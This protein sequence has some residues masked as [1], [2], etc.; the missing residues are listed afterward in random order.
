MGRL[1]C[2]APGGAHSLEG[3]KSSALRGNRIFGRVAGWEVVPENPIHR[4]SAPAAS[5]KLS[6]S[7]C[8][9]HCHSNIAVE[10][11]TLRRGIAARFYL[12]FCPQ[13]SGTLFDWSGS[14][15]RR[16]L[17]IGIGLL[18]IIIIVATLTVS[19]RAQESTPE[20]PATGTIQGTLRDDVG[21]PVEG[22]RVL[23]SSSA[24][25]TKGLTRS[26]KDGAYVSESVPPGVY[27]VRVEGRDML[28]AESSV[29]VVA[30]GEVTADFKWERIT[31]G[32]GR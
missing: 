26:G 22:A 27:V 1:F 16:S 19:L 29:T 21:A 13:E 14:L 24:T 18:F 17:S 23:Y 10:T 8:C 28:P 12:R 3:E 5:S 7:I 32:R 9:R 20:N 30:G 11:K 6:Y 4:P 31:P 2:G 15:V 25:D